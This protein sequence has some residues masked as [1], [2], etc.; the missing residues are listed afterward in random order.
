MTQPTGRTNALC[1]AGH[2]CEVQLVFGPEDHVPGPDFQ[3]GGRLERSGDGKQGKLRWATHLAA[4]LRM[5]LPM[6]ELETPLNV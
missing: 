4:A 3:D 5:L 1:V 6:Q 2:G